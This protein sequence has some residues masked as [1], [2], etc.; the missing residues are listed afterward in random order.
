MA[1]VPPA[2]LA[3]PSAPWPGIVGDRAR[4]VRVS[5]EDAVT[6]AT[7]LTAPACGDLKVARN[8]GLRGDVAVELLISP[9]GKVVAARAI[10]GH[11][12]LRSP[13]VTAALAWTFTPLAASRQLRV[14]T[15]VVRYL[16]QS[17]PY[18]WLTR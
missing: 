14:T 4:E 10:S 17:G 3:Q 18:P 5:P 8:A 7:S 12:A 16:E 13:A 15:L 1:E 9:E 2:L 6:Q 11:S